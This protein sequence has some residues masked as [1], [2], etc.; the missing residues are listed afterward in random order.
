[1]KNVF[2]SKK[3]IVVFAV[4]LVVVAVII[5]AVISNGFSDEA[6]AKRKVQS[7]EKYV[8]ELNYEDAILAYEEAIKLDPRNMDTYLALA[9]AYVTM[10]EPEQAIVVLERGITVAKGVYEEEKLILKNC[11]LL[12]IR[13]CDL[14]F[15][16]G[17]KEEALEKAREGLNFI[18]SPLLE[19]YFSKVSASVSSSL[20]EENVSSDVTA[21]TEIGEKEE[22]ANKTSALTFDEEEGL[23]W[24]VE[25]KV[26]MNY[27]MDALIYFETLDQ[28]K[29]NPAII[30]QAEV[31]E[32]VLNAA[33]GIVVDIS[34]NEETGNTVTVR[35]S[36]EYKVIY[37]QLNE[38]LTVNVGETIEEGEVIGTVA[39]PTKYY[40]KEGTNLFFEVLLNNSTVDPTLLLR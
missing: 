3:V 19:E 26:I 32:D 5:T 14:L 12:Y 1:M 21:D 40:E 36:D 20:P 25:G 39:K 6:R 30:I 10:G 29:C 38:N 37:G 2:K 16:L 7:A 31:G 13:E 18:G 27:S 23:L 28:Y 8:T 17:R 15:E 24:P 9:E 34:Y 4:I 11:D 33:R 35:I 22:A